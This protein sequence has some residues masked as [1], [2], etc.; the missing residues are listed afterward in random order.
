L[1]IFFAL[2]GRPKL[3]LK[4]GDSMPATIWS[5]AISFGLLNIPVSMHTAQ[6]DKNLHFSML[7][8]RDLAP[9]KFRRVNGQS[10]KEV[11]YQKIVKGYKVESGKFVIMSKQDF[12]AANPKATQAIEVEDFVN[13][14][15]I[16]F[17]LFDKPYYLVPKKGG[18]KGYFLLRDALARM[19]KVAVGKIVIRS[20]QHLVAVMP[21]GKYLICE[22]LRFAHQIKQVDE[23]D[24]L[25]DVKDKKRYSDREL[26]MAEQLIDDMSAKWNP[27]KYKDTYYDD[28]M[29]RIK[30]KIKAGPEDVPEIEESAVEPTA[31][32]VDLLPLLR[33]SL[34]A[35]NKKVRKNET[36]RRIH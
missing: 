16:D 32:V 36:S 25:D 4:T 28:I 34:A 15:E 3:P 30:K 13:L 35:K 20:K 23:V 31:D 24:F 29:K 14:D 27:D 21:R 19:K 8:S 18:E 1:P 12:A 22:I 9:I 26:N 2:L 10:G 11:P 5:G 7:D 17:M 6:Q 33:K